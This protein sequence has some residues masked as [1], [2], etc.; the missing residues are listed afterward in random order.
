MK[1]HE[2]RVLAVLLVLFL[3]GGAAHAQAVTPSPQTLQSLQQDLQR[4]QDMM[5]ELERQ[6]NLQQRAT[7]GQGQRGGGG[8]GGIGTGPLVIA[9]VNPDLLNGRVITP[10]GL[11]IANRVV[12]IQ[13]GAAWWTNT[14]LL[15]RLG[16]TEDQKLK[17]GR[18]YESHRQ[19]LVTTKDLLEKE[20][21]QLAKLLE[22]DPLDRTASIAQIYKSI[23]ARGEMEK[24]NGLMT[25]EMRE[26]LTRAQWTQL[27][28][29]QPLELRPLE[30]NIRTQVTPGG[31]RGPGVGGRGAGGPAGTGGPG[32]RGQQ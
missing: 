27:Q 15:T 10:D 32:T 20:E 21:A 6:I 24:V 7:Q 1:R 26:V 11:L 19:N 2:I 23:Q 30:F 3:M 18:V 25:F 31:Q 17:I 8:R 16:L 9:P 14:N 13:G 29:Q 5:R 28:T 4:M 12:S 22:A